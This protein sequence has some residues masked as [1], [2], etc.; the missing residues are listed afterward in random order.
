MFILLL[1]LKRSDFNSNKWEPYFLCHRVLYF[2]WKYMYIPV[3]DMLHH[4]YDNSCQHHLT[5]PF[6]ST[7]LHFLLT[8]QNF[9][10][11]CLLLFTFPSP[12]DV[13]T[14]SPVGSGE[15]YLGMY[16]PQTA[17]AWCKGQDWDGQFLK[18]TSYFYVLNRFT[19]WFSLA[20]SQWQCCIVWML[21]QR[22]G[23]R[24]KNDEE[25]CCKAAI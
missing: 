18:N 1:C 21:R 13:S 17:A 4:C 22:Q 9:S 11:I 19:V 10:E 16:C 23:L 24:K 3:Q 15:L 12:S 8:S 2:L 6:L 14:E 20:L 5:S 25:I 7:V